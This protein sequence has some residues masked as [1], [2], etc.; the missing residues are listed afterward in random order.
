MPDTR[1][2][3]PYRTPR[4]RRLLHVHSSLWHDHVSQEVTSVQFLVLWSLCQYG[5]MRQSHLL[6]LAQIDKSSLAELLKRMESRG[7]ISTI[8]DD[9]DKRCKIISITDDGRG[10]HDELS[11]GA[12]RVNELMASGLTATELATLDA[13]FDKVLASKIVREV[14]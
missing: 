1:P 3:P 11:D 4:L 8:R 13:L 12:V 5:A 6:H 10:I 2:L 9:A 14:D 7:L